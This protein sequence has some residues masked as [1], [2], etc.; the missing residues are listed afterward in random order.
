MEWRAIPDYPGYEVSR[1]GIIR[2]QASGYVY[3]TTAK[4]RVNGKQKWC[5]GRKFARA[6]FGDMPADLPPVPSPFIVVSPASAGTPAPAPAPA[7]DIAFPAPPLDEVMRS[8]RDAARAA[9]DEA[10]QSLALSRR[11]NGHQ[12]ALIDRL[13]SIINELEAGAPKPRRGRKRKEPAAELD[14][15]PS[16]GDV[17]ALTFEDGYF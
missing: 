5:S 14:Y 4:L 13:R 1:R 17:D 11:V 12:M 15:L 9:L 6:V 10:R 3:G 7:P 16:A 8:E 2:K